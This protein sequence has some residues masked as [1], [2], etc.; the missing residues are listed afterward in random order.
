M[1]HELTQYDFD[2]PAIEDWLSGDDRTLAFV[3][4]DAAGDPVDIS[5]A[6]VAWALYDRPY[7]DDPA[8]ATLSDSDSGVEL[9]TDNR[10]DTTAGEWE[11][12][13][14]AAATVDLWGDFTHRPSVTQTDGTTAT[15]IGDVTI[16]A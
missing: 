12:R 1:P 14:D 10:V 3:V 9:V 5:G 2:L 13:I 7:N 6:T 8:N 11:V 4:V 15:W 16:T